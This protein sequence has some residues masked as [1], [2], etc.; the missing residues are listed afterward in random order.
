MPD[1]LNGRDRTIEEWVKVHRPDV[2]DQVQKVLRDPG[3]GDHGQM[4][5]ALHWMLCMGF[6]AGRKFQADRPASV[7]DNPNI[8][9]R[10]FGDDGNPRNW[11]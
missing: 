5:T 9:L 1:E 4:Y 7:L 3:N 2:L 6:E 10:E 8:Y 11:T